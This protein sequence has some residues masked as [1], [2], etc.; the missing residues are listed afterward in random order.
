MQV[1]L[2]FSEVQPIFWACAASTKVSANRAKNQIFIWIFD[3][4]P[5]GFSSGVDLKV[6]KRRLISVTKSLKIVQLTHERARTKLA[7]VLVASEKE[8]SEAKPSE[9]ANLFSS[10]HPECSIVS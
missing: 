6:P 5:F 7:W 10:S 2:R 3:F 8:E 9:N 1:Y 4:S